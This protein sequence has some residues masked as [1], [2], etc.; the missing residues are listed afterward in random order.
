MILHSSIFQI[1]DV[2]RQNW[3]LETKY[4]VS[5]LIQDVKIWQENGY[6]DFC[7]W[8][9]LSQYVTL[10]LL[11]MHF[12]TATGVVLHTRATRGIQELSISSENYVF[13]TEQG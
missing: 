12:A 4:T 6:L 10:E 5:D 8:Q 13:I 9:N 1:L 7:T 3:P 11:P 2:W